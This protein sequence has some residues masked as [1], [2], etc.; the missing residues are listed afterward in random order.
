[1]GGPGLLPLTPCQRWQLPRP[2]VPSTDRSLDAPLQLTLT[3]CYRA[4][5]GVLALPPATQLPTWVHTYEVCARPE[6]LNG[7]NRDTRAACRLS[8]S[9]IELSTS[10]PQNVP[11][12][13][14]VAIANY[15]AGKWTYDLR[16][17]SNR[18]FTGQGLHHFGDNVSTHRGKRSPLWIYPNLID[19]DTICR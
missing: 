5:T 12:P 7:I 2:E 15:R 11:N 13:T 4:A 17:T 9:A 18:V 16:S 8:N 1:M 14:L 6:R 19:S 3:F 10:T